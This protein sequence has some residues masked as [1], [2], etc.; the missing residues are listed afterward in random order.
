MNGRNPTPSDP[1]DGESPDNPSTHGSDDPQRM[2]KPERATR[3]MR[4]LLTNLHNFVEFCGKHPFATGL[5]ALLSVVGLALSI[6][7]YRQDREEA[8]STTEQVDLVQQKVNEIATK[9]D[10]SGRDWQVM[11]ST[12]YGIRIGGSVKPAYE[13]GFQ[14]IS[15][16]GKG[17]VKHIVWRLEN[18]NIFSV[19]YDSVQDR[20][21]RIT[22]DW[23][24]KHN[25][26]E[27]SISDFKFGETTLQ[28]IRDTFESNGFSYARRVMSPQEDGIVTYN[29][30]ELQDTPTIIIV[31][32]TFLSYD[33]KQLID[34]L[35]A[36][37]Q[38][39]GA[40]GPHFRLI[41][42]IVADESHLDETWGENKIYDPGSNPIKLK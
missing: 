20:V 18:D 4:G 7:G 2:P 34:Q 15:R 37:Q 32:K 5:F 28:D 35:P 24:G 6:V 12:F 8:L 26:R 33:V 38:V 13:L 41:G 9:L 21:L 1:G 36:E 17:P 42:I 19:A 40:L 22:L 23:G 31:F 29:A 39:L 11:E 14:R 16:T 3:S 27:I 30:F 10:T 25:G